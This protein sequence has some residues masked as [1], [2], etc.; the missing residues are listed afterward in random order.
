MAKAV[1]SDLS[2]GSISS[3]ISLLESEAA[4]VDNLVNAINS[5]VNDSTS[6]LVGASYNAARQKL[7]LYLHDIQ[8][9]KK[10]STNKR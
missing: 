3:M 4:N 5:F 6:S 7:G 10:I 9:R 1:K 8:T 2:G